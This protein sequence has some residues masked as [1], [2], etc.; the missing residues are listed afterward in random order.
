MEY[1]YIKKLEDINIINEIEQKYKVKIPKILKDTIIRY[2]GGRPVKNTFMTKEKSEKVIKTLL[3]YNQS[4][5]EN[6]YIYLDFFKKGYIPFANTDF[7]DVI[8]LNNKNENIELYLHEIDK[9][10]YV[11]E[12]IEQFIN[13]LYN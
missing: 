7:G 6:I 8:C 12:N 4:D 3:S 9:F 11:C 5:R 1:K 10:E 13:K 2:N